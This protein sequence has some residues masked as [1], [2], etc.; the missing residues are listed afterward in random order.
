[1]KSFVAAYKEQSERTTKFPRFERK[2]EILANFFTGISW[3]R[4]VPACKAGQNGTWGSYSLVPVLPLRIPQLVSFSFPYLIA[5]TGL[6]PSPLVQRRVWVA[7]M[8][9][10]FSSSVSQWDASSFS[11]RGSFLP[12]LR[13]SL[14]LARGRTRSFLVRKFTHALFSLA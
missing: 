12:L 9:S 7:Q 1:M 5:L 11:R 8:L 6:P 3:H 2:Q 10:S 14:H 13:V 4:T